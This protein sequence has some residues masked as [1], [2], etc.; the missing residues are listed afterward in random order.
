MVENQARYYPMVGDLVRVVENHP[1][2]E[3]M[4]GKVTEYYVFKKSV[5]Q[6]RDRFRVLLLP[7]L[8]VLEC[9]IGDVRPVTPKPLVKCSV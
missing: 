6:V 5:G 7:S 1:E 3:G 8:H 2:F 4:I 9:R